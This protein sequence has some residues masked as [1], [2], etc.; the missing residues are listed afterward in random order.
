MAMT[1]TV[2][3]LHS[4]GF[5][6]GPDPD[7]P[8]EQA[9]CGHLWGNHLLVAPGLDPLDGGT[10]TCPFQGCECAGTWGL[11]DNARSAIETYRSRAAN[12]EQG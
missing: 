11:R 12:D 4:A 8:C 5:P 3:R 10:Y 2:D 1:T 9:R 6:L 7:G